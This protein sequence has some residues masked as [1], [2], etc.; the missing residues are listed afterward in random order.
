MNRFIVAALLSAMAGPLAAQVKS[1]E[2]LYQDVSRSIVAIQVL[3]RE[4]GVANLG[5]S[6]VS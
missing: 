3:D 1:P 5:S 2:Q 4:G 6:M